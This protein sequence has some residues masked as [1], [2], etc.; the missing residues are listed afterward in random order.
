MK[1]NIL[2]VGVIALLMAGAL[3]LIGCK[4]P[5]EIEMGG[6]EIGITSGGIKA[7]LCGN[8]SCNLVK[9]LNSAEDDTIGLP[10]DCDCSY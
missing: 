9:Y 7:S 10:G 8:K 5:C 6:C 2:I 4:N 1:K 3:F